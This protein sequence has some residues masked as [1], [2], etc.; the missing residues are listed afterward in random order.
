[1][2]YGNNQMNI[3]MIGFIGLVVFIFSLGVT[4]QTII[5]NKPIQWKIKKIK[6]SNMDNT[7]E[8]EREAHKQSHKFFHHDRQNVRYLMQDT[9]EEGFLAGAKWQKEREDRF[10]PTH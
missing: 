5:S 9:F 6:R 2:G 3:K 4:Y 8:A 10:S 7:E 1:M